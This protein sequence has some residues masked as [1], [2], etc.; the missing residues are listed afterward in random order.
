MLTS[1][2]RCFKIITTQPQFPVVVIIPIHKIE[3]SS[4]EQIALKQCLTVLS[5]HQM[6]IIAPE[7][8]ALERL[9]LSHPNVNVELF[10]K[11]WFRNELQY[12]K[13][14]LSPEFYRRFLRY[15][16]MLICQLDTFIFKDELL[17]WCEQGFDYI[18]AP[19]FNDWFQEYSSALMKGLQ[20]LHI[21]F[22]KRVG[23]G[24]LSLRHVKK[25]FLI[26]RMFRSK[27]AR[28][29]ERGTHFHEDLF[30]S[31]FVT[32]Y[33]P[34]FKVPNIQTAL[35]FSF[36]SQPQACYELNHR[37]LPFGCHAWEKHGLEFWRPFLEEYGY[38]L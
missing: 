31:Y 8:L 37:E 27:A 15:K 33:I 11:H 32:S 3:L 16:F 2:C 18:G 20:F 9:H 23:N 7:G 19:W 17:Y 22:E 6:T 29:G 4:F 1:V 25:C 24:G 35:R 34:F 36:E 26:V 21:P 10:D 14:M 13:L 5:R 38:T 30:W 12:N 28:W